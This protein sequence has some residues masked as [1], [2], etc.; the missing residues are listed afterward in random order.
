M[1][2]P[3]R[4]TFD[5]TA[6]QANDCVTNTYYELDFYEVNYSRW[7]DGKPYSFEYND[8]GNRLDL[9]TAD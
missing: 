6:S 4:Q 3:I 5:S 9:Y 1:A 2:G 7:H 8:S